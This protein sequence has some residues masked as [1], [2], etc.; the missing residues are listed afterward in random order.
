MPRYVFKKSLKVNKVNLIQGK[1]AAFKAK[2]KK[3]IT[4]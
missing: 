3:K 2:H 4:T 1:I